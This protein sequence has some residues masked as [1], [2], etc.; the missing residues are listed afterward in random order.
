MSLP[1]LELTQIPIEAHGAPAPPVQHSLPR[2]SEWR[3]EVAF[4]RT[5]RVKEPQSSS[6][7]NWPPPKH[8]LSPEQK[9]QSTHGTAVRWK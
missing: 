4:G 6:A 1:G 8:T 5:V 7:P 9:P 2:G 3:F